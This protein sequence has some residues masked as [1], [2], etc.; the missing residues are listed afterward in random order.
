MQCNGA[1]GSRYETIYHLTPTIRLNNGFSLG[2]DHVTSEGD[3][4]GEVI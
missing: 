1:N 2:A 3:G 4:G